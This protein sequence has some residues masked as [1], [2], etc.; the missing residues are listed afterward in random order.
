MSDVLLPAMCLRRMNGQN[1]YHKLY[2]SLNTIIFKEETPPH[3][4]N[5]I[6]TH[7]KMEIFQKNDHGAIVS[8]FSESDV[9]NA[10]KFLDLNRNNFLGK[11]LPSTTVSSYTQSVAA[12]FH[13]HPP[14][15]LEWKLFELE[16]S[17][18]RID[19]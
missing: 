3:H 5:I 18:L 2:Y 4:P 11:M 1:R 16:C 13:P 17:F 9:A 19:E 7:S 6:V 12:H 15:L 8:E 10:F 14:P